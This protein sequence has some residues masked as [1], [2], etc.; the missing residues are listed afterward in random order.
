MKVFSPVP[1]RN[2][3]RGPGRLARWIVLAIFKIILL[4]LAA[5]LGSGAVGLAAEDESRQPSTGADASTGTIAYVRNG[6]DI[7][8][9]E[10]DGSNNRLLWRS[11]DPGVYGVMELDWKP[12]AA[13][14]AF[15]SDHEIGCSIFE[16][17]IYAI[18]PDGSGL[19]RITNAPACAGLAGYPKGTVTVTVE[20]YIQGGGPY[21]VYVQGAPSI[22]PV[23]VP[24]GGAVT[25]TFNNVADFGD[26]YQQAVVMEGLNR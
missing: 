26:T 20:N 5:L 25:V 23:I 13:E 21:F 16:M 19:R 4:T 17:D 24:A 18:R 3:S 6:S 1:P 9:I 11:P 12:D 14:V 8:L 15:A 22:L 10:P 2:L 7:R